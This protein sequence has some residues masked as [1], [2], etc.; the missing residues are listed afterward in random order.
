MNDKK[1]IENEKRKYKKVYGGH[2]Y[3]LDKFS[4]VSKWGQALQKDGGQALQKNGG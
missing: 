1:T 3:T 2:V 4:E